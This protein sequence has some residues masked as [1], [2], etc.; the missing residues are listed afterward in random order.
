MRLDLLSEGQRVYVSRL[1]CGTVS[2][3]NESL[4]SVRNVSVV[5]EFD[6]GSSVR[7]V[8][9]NMT[10]Q[11]DAGTDAL[12]YVLDVPDLSQYG[13]GLSS[14]VT[15]VVVTQS[16]R[17]NDSEVYMTS[18]QRGV[19]L[20]AIDRAYDA[21]KSRCVTG[22][23]RG[24]WVYYSPEDGDCGL[25]HVHLLAKYVH[26]GVHHTGTIGA[27]DEMNAHHDTLGL[28]PN[29]MSVNGLGIRCD[30]DRDGFENKYCIGNWSTCSMP[31]NQSWDLLPVDLGN[32]LWNVT[33][34]GYSGDYVEQS[35]NVF[36]GTVQYN[37]VLYK[38]LQ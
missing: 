17:A 38:Y 15:L 4:W 5:L 32:G 27:D 21:S 26:L 36:E 31:Y 10:S 28:Y 24:G 25:D 2:A 29:N 7:S 1:L 13:V 12:K 34:P 16:K 9:L 37:A 8:R 20:E 22:S 19:L 11:T 33:H 30:F 14:L 6:E 3:Q 18:D 35:E 23:R